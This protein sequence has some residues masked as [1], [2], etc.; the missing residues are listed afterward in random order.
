[1]LL[2]TFAMSGVEALEFA[3][4]AGY[5]A[6]G[7]AMIQMSKIWVSIPYLRTNKISYAS[8]VATW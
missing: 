3:G 1:L 8:V 5:G 2:F 4:V 7:V 6:R